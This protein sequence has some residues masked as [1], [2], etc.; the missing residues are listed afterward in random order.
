MEL[1][2][3]QRQQKVQEIKEEHSSEELLS[4]A[5][6]AIDDKQGLETACFFIADISTV[7]DYTIVSTATSSTH[8]RV[9]ADTVRRAMKKKKYEQLNVGQQDDDVW[10]IL[11][12]GTTIVHIMTATS[13]EHYNLEKMWAEGKVVNI[14]EMMA[15]NP[16]DL[17]S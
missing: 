2:E 12:F 14:E 6:H 17:S 3:E 16:C 15:S 5:L 13:R 9:I 4:L 11:D 1:T 8:L 7:A 10:T